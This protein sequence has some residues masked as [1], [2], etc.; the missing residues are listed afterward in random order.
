MP[1]EGA[2]GAHDGRRVLADPTVV[3]VPDRDGVEVVALLAPDLPRRD[4]TR[5]LQDVQV[6]HDPEAGH[7]GQPGRELA[8]RLAIALEEPIQEQASTRVG[9]R[10]ERRS[11]RVVHVTE[12]M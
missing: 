11:R 5:P 1:F 12:I 3:D 9:Q 10:P 8:E 6:L 7:V 4:Q 2:H